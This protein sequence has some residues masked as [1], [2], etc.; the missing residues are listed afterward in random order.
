MNGLVI[1]PRGGAV[2]MQS[3]TFIGKRQR[4]SVKKLFFKSGSYFSQQGL[5]VIYHVGF[6]E[7]K[8]V[9]L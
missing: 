5:E 8:V 1:A 3:Y 2:E 6:G 9:T 4:N 7:G